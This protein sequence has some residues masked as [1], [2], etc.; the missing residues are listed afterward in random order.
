VF[1]TREV[2]DRFQEL[3]AKSTGFHLEQQPDVGVLRFSIIANDAIDIRTYRVQV[4]LAT[5]TYECSC[6]LFDMCGLLCPH[7]VRVMVHLNIQEIPDRYL[8][9]RWSATATVD[10]PVP[11]AY[12]CTTNFGIPGTNTL[13]YNRL[14]RKN[15]SISLKCLL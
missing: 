15:E 11:N 14:C 10:A 6:N 9:K 8:L 5:S 3:I 4:D 13:R 2:F 12:N 1:Y 7:I